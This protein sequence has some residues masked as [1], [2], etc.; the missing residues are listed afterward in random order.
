MG[1]SFVRGIRQNVSFVSLRD[2]QSDVGMMKLTLEH[3]GGSERL[4]R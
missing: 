3:M 2:R 1:I 4:S